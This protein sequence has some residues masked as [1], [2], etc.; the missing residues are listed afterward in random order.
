VKFF[1][2]RTVIVEFKTCNR[3]LKRATLSKE[4][5]VGQHGGGCLTGTF[6]RQTEGS[7]NETSPIKLIWAPIF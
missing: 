1:I 3:F 7:G 5:P 2:R 4:A 6:E